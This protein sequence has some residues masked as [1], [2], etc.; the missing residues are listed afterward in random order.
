MGAVIRETVF[1]WI[2]LRKRRSGKTKENR[3]VLGSV[4]SMTSSLSFDESYVGTLLYLLRNSPCVVCYSVGDVFKV[5]EK[6][7]NYA[8]LQDSLK[9]VNVMKAI[10]ASCDFRPFFFPTI[11]N[12]LKRDVESDIVVGDLMRVGSLTKAV[13]LSESRVLALRDLYLFI[14]TNGFAITQHKD[15]G[16]IRKVRV[17]GDY[18]QSNYFVL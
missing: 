10:E 14:L 17:P 7:N 6:Y 13:S 8:L 2:E 4:A 11:E 3:L 5:L 15:G 18:L 16:Q 9:Y 1:L 12:T